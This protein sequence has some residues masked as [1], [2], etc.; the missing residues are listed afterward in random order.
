MRLIPV[1]TPRLLK[2]FYPE[3]IWDIK[4]ADK[5][6]YLTFDD[7]P[8]PEITEFVLAQLKKHNA[9]AT[10]FCIGSNV[11]NHPELF[12]KTI[13]QGHAIGNHTMNHIKGW[14]V[15]DKQYFEEVTKALSAFQVSLSK[16]EQ[17]DKL[18][19]N[20]L[21]PYPD[22][23]LSVSTS[24]SKLFRPPYGQIKRSQGKK[25]IGLGYDIIMWD[26]LSFDWSADVSEKQC[27]NYVTSKST[28]GSIIAFHDSLKASRNMMYALPRILEYFSGLGFKFKAIE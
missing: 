24:S 10:F 16:V 25:L 5:T 22:N 26:V 23:Q 13:A 18:K 20:H 21:K 15:N 19:I 2:H 14:K 27:L 1:K 4:T 11:V 9:K 17:F 7:G 8:T 3:Y 6:I 12:R 28:S